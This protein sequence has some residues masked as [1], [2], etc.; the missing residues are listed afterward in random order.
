M[1]KSF[2]KLL[3]KFSNSFGSNKVFGNFVEAPKYDLP[4]TI[5]SYLST[6]PQK[7]GASYK[8]SKPKFEKKHPKLY[9]NVEEQV[10]PMYHTNYFAPI[11]FADNLHNEEQALKTRVTV[12][13]PNPDLEFIQ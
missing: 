8:L 2:G 11:C 3:T 4:T 1:F 9:D 5:N 10:K 7:P 6:P 12:A 13:T